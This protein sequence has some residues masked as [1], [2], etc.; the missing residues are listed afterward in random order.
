MTDSAEPL[1][2]DEPRA[3][4]VAAE[5]S[6]TGTLAL[7]ALSDQEFDRRLAALE[8]GRDRVARIQRALMDK[9]VDYGIIPGT[10]K[11]T[12][13]K[14]GAEKLCQAYSL[15][16]DFAPERYPGDNITVPALAFVT[17][18]QLHLG[19]LDGPVVAVGYGEANS[20]ERKHRY[21]RGEL[22]CPACAKEGT[23]LRSKNEPEYFCWR[24]KG[25]CG[26]TFPL[27]DERITGQ[28]VGDVENPDP[29]DLGTTLLKMAEKR[30]FVDATLRATAASGLFTQDMEDQRPPDPASDRVDQETGEILGERV[31]HR[32]ADAKPD[33]GLR[34]EPWLD[35]SGAKVFGT[36]ELGKPPADGQL[37]MDPDAVPH[38]V[39]RLNTADGKII[40]QVTAEGPLAEDIFDATG[41]GNIAGLAVTAEGDI[42]RVPWQKAMRGKQEWMPAFQRLLLSRVSWTDAD[43]VA[44][45]LPAPREAESVAMGLVP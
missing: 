5:M 40:P 6:A 19:S 20:W 35:I 27:A 23:V 44:V 37:R 33:N 9:D 18:C 39:F 41:G 2:L 7:A 29:W 15:A 30:A 16:A 43:G 42:W 10:P 24:K 45:S 3:L 25:G 1:V 13:L 21:R 22:V 4:V 17:R 31:E 28:S 12:L 11:P 34:T 38:L 32:A 8:K 36:I 14:P 26:A